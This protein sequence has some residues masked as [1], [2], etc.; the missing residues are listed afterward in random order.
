[1]FFQFDEKTLKDAI[2]NQK[3]REAEAKAN[4]PKFEYE[5]HK[6]KFFHAVDGE[7]IV[8]ADPP[9]VTEVKEKT[10]E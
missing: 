2:E 1:M 8:D 7:L 9:L 10:S 6:L 3:R 4:E 5:G